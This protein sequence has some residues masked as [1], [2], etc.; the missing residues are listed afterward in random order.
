MTKKILE[1][2]S[3]NGMLCVDLLCTSGL[4]VVYAVDLGMEFLYM[5]TG[6]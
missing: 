1:N 3:I 4:M 6:I 5:I 2:K